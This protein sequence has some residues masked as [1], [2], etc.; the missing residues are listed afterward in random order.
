MVVLHHLYISN[1]VEY[2]QM[3]LPIQYQVQVI[4]ML[5]D[6]QGHQGMKRTIALCSEHLYW[7]M[8]YKDIA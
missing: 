5:H 3:I 6:G 1:D 7:N 4:Q 8:M 2:H